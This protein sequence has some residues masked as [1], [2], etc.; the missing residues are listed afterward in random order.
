[1]EPG[2]DQTAQGPKSSQIR[3]RS[4]T[5]K[6]FSIA[7]VCIFTLLISGCGKVHYPTYYTLSIA[8]TITPDPKTPD[9]K[10]PD[11]KTPSPGT[12]AVRQFETPEYLRQGRIV[13]SKAPGDIGFYEYHRWAVDPGA[14]VTT[15]VVGSLRSQNLFSLVA[16]Y[17]GQ[18]RPDYL[19]TGRLE[20]LDEI[21]YGGGVNAEAKL[22]A[23][24]TNLRTGAVVWT[25]DAA[26]T[27]KVDRRDVNSVVAEMNRA[28]QESIDRLLTSMAQQLAGSEISSR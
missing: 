25:G 27:S 9:P 11:P 2:A 16:R 14:A 15:A 23:E 6:T 17:E 12:V 26:G 13:Y 7:T 4:M 24:L 8:P 19:L 21:D 1:M 18:A 10:T 28:L 5:A 3:G 20:K 22:S